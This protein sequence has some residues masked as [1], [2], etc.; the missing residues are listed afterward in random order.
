M[1]E[2]IFGIVGIVGAVITIINYILYVRETRK[3]EPKIIHTVL[4][5][6]DTGDFQILVTVSNV[7]YR[8]AKNCSAKIYMQDNQI[9]DLSFAPIDSPLGRIGIDWPKD[10]SF[11]IHPNTPIMV[12]A[13][14]SPEFEGKKVHVRLF[15]GGKEFDR[16]NSFTLTKPR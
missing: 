1:F 3:T 7:G 4:R 2:V 5:I 12:R 11:D 16:S 10:T 13:Y 9:E 14:L 6:M 8:S 15:S